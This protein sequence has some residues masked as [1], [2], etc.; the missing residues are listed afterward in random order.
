MKS[1]TYIYAAVFDGLNHLARIFP[2]LALWATNI[3]P[4]SSAKTG[5]SKP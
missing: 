5:T 2:Q 4:I 1:A 3:S